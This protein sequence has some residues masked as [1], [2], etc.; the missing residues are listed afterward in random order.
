MSAMKP[1]NP[2]PAVVWYALTNL[3]LALSEPI[4][5]ELMRP[6]MRRRLPLLAML[7]MVVHPK[8]AM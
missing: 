7:W 6:P 5:V 1:S 3:L 4:W 2:P 8:R